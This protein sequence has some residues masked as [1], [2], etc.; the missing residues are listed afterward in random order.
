M[1]LLI[2]GVLGVL[3][4]TVSTIS[5]EDIMLEEWNA[6]KAAHGKAYPNQ[7]EDA[8]RMKVYMKNKV[9]IVKH[10]QL[11]HK[12]NHSYFLKMNRFGDLLPS[13]IAALYGLQHV[14]LNK[15]QTEYLDATFIAPEGFEA[16][17]EVDWRTKGA[18]TE[19]RDQ[20]KCGSCF[21]MAVAGSVES[22][23]FRKTGKLISLSVQ[24]LVD[25]SQPF[26]DVCK[27]GALLFAFK[28]IQDKGID[29]EKS[30]PYVSGKTGV[31]QKKCH[32][33][34]STVGSTITGMARVP[35]GDEN[36]LALA[37][38]ANG[39]TTI[40]VDA[41]GFQ[42][43]YYSHGI[44]SHDDCSNNIYDINHAMLIV[45][46]GPGYWLV[47]NSWGK[48]WGMKGYIKFKRGINMCGIANDPMYPLS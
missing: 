25:C 9:K 2:V 18:V 6:F 14:G 5:S 3:A 22:Q 8:S 30:Y 41:S 33:N 23:H 43:L 48:G 16:P 26:D 42:F 46:Y 4:T 15:T 35:K 24:Q 12:G 11:A 36:A 1:R 45:G 21:A 10:N 31:M 38:A 13:E 29:T 37:V 27:G 17:T 19:V 40:Q 32:F 20:G 44:Y 47:K 39:P 7:K 34:K 28:Y